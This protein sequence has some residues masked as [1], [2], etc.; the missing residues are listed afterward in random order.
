MKKTGRSP[1]PAQKT[2]RITMI[3]GHRSSPGHVQGQPTLFPQAEPSIYDPGGFIGRA[4]SRPI[5]P[6][7][8]CAGRHRGAETSTQ[9]HAAILPTKRQT[10]ERIMA[11]VQA[12]GDAGATVHELADAM[13][14]TPNCVSG[15]LTEL[16]A[17]GRLTFALDAAG[18]NVKRRG[19]CVLVETGPAP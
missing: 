13:G 10:H 7:D 12:R 3:L 1:R 17:L 2:D 8:P 19:A 18:N 6:A 11:I 5:F 4:V 9:A 14:T 16:R 15:R